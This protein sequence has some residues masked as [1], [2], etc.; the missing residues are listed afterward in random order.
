[1]RQAHLRSHM[2][3]LQGH[4]AICDAPSFAA[5]LKAALSNPSAV[6]RLALTREETAQALGISTTGLWRLEKAGRIRASE[7]GLARTKLF[8]VRE[9]ERFLSGK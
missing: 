6:T 7:T 4:E 5:L 9:I 2:Q 1:M 3:Q 8:S